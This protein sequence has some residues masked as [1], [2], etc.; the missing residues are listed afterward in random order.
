[1]ATRQVKIQNYLNALQLVGDAGRAL[2]TAAGSQGR[3]AAVAPALESIHNLQAIGELC[4]AA[5]RAGHSAEAAP[6]LHRAEVATAAEPYRRASD[7]AA[8]APAFAGCGRDP[9]PLIA[10]AAQTVGQHP[11]AA[12]GSERSAT[13]PRRRATPDSSTRRGWRSPR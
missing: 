4:R 2:A 12:A 1:M 7:L 10:E 3:V 8:L 5:G 11:T 9:A 13:S 6:V